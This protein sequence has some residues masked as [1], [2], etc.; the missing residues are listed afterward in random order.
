MNK[1]LW[2]K[3]V[4]LLV[5][6]FFIIPL[7]SPAQELSKFHDDL[8]FKAENNILLQ[9]RL[10]S[11]ISDNIKYGEK[12]D[13]AS[14]GPGYVEDM[15]TCI[16]RDMIMR[17]DKDLKEDDSRHGVWVV[18][19]RGASYYPHSGIHNVV[20]KWGDTMMGISFP[21]LVD[22]HGAW[23]AGQGGG[24]D[25]WTK[26]IRAIGYR[27][28]E[29]VKNTDW[30]EDIDNIPSW[31]AIN[32][33]DIDRIVI[34][35]SPVFN[36][37]GW[38]AMDDLTYTPK[39]NYEQEP[40]N[41]V[42]LDFEDCYFKQNL[43]TTNYAGL[44]WETGTGNF[45]VEQTKKSDSYISYNENDL[46]EFKNDSTISYNFEPIDPPILLNDYQGVIRGD[47][48]SWS[49]PP[50]SCGAAG[51]NHFVEVVNRNFA[52]YN[53]STGEELINI[54]LGAFLPESNGDPRVLYDQYSDRWFVIVCDFNT[55]LF[56]AVSK[57][58]DPTGSWFKCSFVVSE[59]SD[60]GKWPDYPTLG[61]DEDGIYTAAYMIGGSGGMS[62]F[63]LEK[64]PL[65]DE[66]PSLGDIYAFRELPWEG[67]I[68]P[69]H[70]FG[71]TE[72]EYF[73]SR[74]SSTTLRVRILTDLLSTPI[75]TELCF[76]NI[77]SHSQPPDAPALGSTVPLDTVG[78]RLMNAVYR[79]GYIWTAHCIDVG[80]RAA[81]RWY[82]V[83]VSNTS[84]DDSGT[85]EDP[86][87]YYFFPTI[88]VNPGG[89]VI[90]G[91]SG[92]CSGQ[93][94]AA[95]YTGR[96]ASD[97]PGYMAPPVLYKEGEATY[98]LIDSYGRNRWGDYSLCSLDPVKNTLWTIQEY[99]HS[100]NESDENRW[101]T[102]ICELVFNQPPGTPTKPDGPE[103][104]G[105]YAE[106]TFSTSAIDPEG[107]D[108]YYKFNWGDGSFSDWVG[109]YASGE[110]GVASNS[111]ADSGEFEVKA[112]AKDINDIQSKWSEP[113]IVTII[114]NDPPEKVT[115]N[116]PSLG[117]GGKE[118]EYT[119]ISTDTEGQDIYYKVKWDDGEETDWL[120]PYSS[121]EQIKLS[122]SWNKKGEYWI[123]AWAKD[124]YESCSNQGMFKMTIL[125]NK[126]KSVNIYN[127]PLFV[128]FFEKL[129]NR[130]PILIHIL[131]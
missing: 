59:G 76:V 118:Y 56:L 125:T 111:W 117:L 73:V 32:L 67:A 131:N 97:P 22:V 99:A 40:P 128:Q 100:H 75:L 7:L 112:I 108:V 88:M 10:K 113:A 101:G 21:N 116:G 109:P 11:S 129:M 94:A 95:Y 23:F 15:D 93:Y 79:D 124:I 46:S 3:I 1:N 14:Y 104:L 103:I 50:D 96:S 5:M 72:G 78:H 122:H 54:L 18:P 28:G 13:S 121:G 126:A 26:S 110:T 2:N 102:W 51:P 9:Q 52:V 70:T 36:G 43:N 120:G 6:F 38:Y 81:S 12:L 84:L 71:T 39:T 80:G 42:V 77:P 62:I 130:F 27:N 60:Q 16:A 106:A 8:N 87:L 34:E 68:Q 4:I 86:V 31:F 19:P 98:N 123:K 41:T 105:Q 107:E 64:A 82:K 20:N 85:I 66:D 33:E 48:T 53:K 29:H 17:T 30:F 74:G 114:E 63:A 119:F 91:F 65:I 35:A 92:S 49:Y 69:V 57:S 25:V 115:I 127:S 45:N 58:D 83:D 90:M 24:K 37:A 89:D 47:A 55:K 44:S 61:V